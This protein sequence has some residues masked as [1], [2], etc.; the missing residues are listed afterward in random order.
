[1][2]L[3]VVNKNYFLRTIRKSAIYSRLLS[4]ISLRDHIQRHAKKIKHGKFNLPLDTVA[5]L[6]IF[7]AVTYSIS[8]TMTYR[9]GNSGF[10]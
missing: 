1:M 4:S 10:H 3:I 9:I 2:S 7:V 8:V 5:L 6:V